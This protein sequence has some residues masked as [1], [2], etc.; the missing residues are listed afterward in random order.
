VAEEG[1]VDAGFFETLS[2]GVPATAVVLEENCGVAGRM[3]G[4]VV[5]RV[6]IEVHANQRVEPACLAV[7]SPH[8]LVVPVG[9]FPPQAFDR[10]GFREAVQEARFQPFALKAELLPSLLDVHHVEDTAK[11]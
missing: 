2:V 8:N 9:F 5:K 1:F 7:A 3:V 11:R 6:R 4:I 10:V